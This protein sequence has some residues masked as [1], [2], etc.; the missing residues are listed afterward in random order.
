MLKQEACKDLA[1]VEEWLKQ[2]A[3]H[4]NNLNEICAKLSEPGWD[5]RKSAAKLEDILVRY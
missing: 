1:T 4:T 5:S 3:T 2:H